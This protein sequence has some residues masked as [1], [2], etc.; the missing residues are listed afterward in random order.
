MKEFDMEAVVQLYGGKLLRYAYTL[1]CDFQEAEDVVQD[2]FISAYQAKE[3]FDGKNLSA[4]LYKIAYNKSVDRLRKKKPISL[5]ELRES[6]YASEDSYDM[7]YD[8]KII[9]ALKTLSDADRFILLGR[10]TES[11]GYGEIAHRLKLSE[12][13]VRKRYERAKRKV[14]EQ[15][16]QAESEVS[17]Y[18]F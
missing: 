6:D 10:I 8:P 16:R 18:E 2:V 7:G 13:T 1:L 5:Q 4:W 15:L 12:T 9:A 11:L 17:S 14:A 3:G